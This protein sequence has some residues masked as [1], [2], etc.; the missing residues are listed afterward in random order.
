MIINSYISYPSVPFLAYSFRKQLSLCW[1]LK[2]THNCIGFILYFL[3]TGQTVASVHFLSMNHAKSFLKILA[4]MNLYALSFCIS[5][6]SKIQP[7]WMSSIVNSFKPSSVYA[8][9]TKHVIVGIRRYGLKCAEHSMILLRYILV[10]RINFL[11]P[12]KTLLSVECIWCFTSYFSC[13]IS[14][15]HHAGFMPA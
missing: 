14:L 11:C 9:S 1:L 4:S 5:D 3:F 6:S 8:Y 10:V 7:G 15:D 12:S 13:S 2:K